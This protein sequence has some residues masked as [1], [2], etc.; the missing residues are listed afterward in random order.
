MHYQ[1]ENN[2]KYQY[3]VNDKK[4]YG[5]DTNKG[6]SVEAPKSVQKLLE[7]DDFQKGIDKGLKYLG[8]NPQ[9]GN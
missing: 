4:F 6:F 8:E 3:N 9:Y 5:Q 2:I 7:N 1:D